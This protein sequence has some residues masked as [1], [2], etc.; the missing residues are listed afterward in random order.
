MNKS[1]VFLGATGAVGGEA[2]NVLLA[3]NEVNKITLLG[4]NPVPDI[5]QKKV[6]QVK[7]NIF[8]S[9]SYDGHINGHDVAICTLGVGQPSKMS[10]EDFIKIDKNAVIDFARSCKEQGVK[11]F[12]LLSS[13]G[14]NSSS[15]SFYLRSKGELID[16]LEAIG[17]E[18]LSIF[19]PSMILT[20]K[21]RYGV[22]QGLTLAVWPI[23]NPL[24]FG[25]LKLYKG[26]KVEHLGKAIALNSFTIFKGKE[27]LTWKDFIDFN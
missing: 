19:Q 26:I 27:F 16:D 1:I 8:D 17:F 11:H 2:L 13:V 24:L 5:N 14:A 18:R 25:S 22:L 20:P 15:S 9:S 12:Q 23:L 21:N 7:V 6:V 3:H 10:K 4:R